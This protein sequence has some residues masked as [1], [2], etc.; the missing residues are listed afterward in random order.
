MKLLIWIYNDY[1]G[2]GSPGNWTF[3]RCSSPN[4]TKMIPSGSS[5]GTCRSHKPRV[6][7]GIGKRKSTL[8]LSQR[9]CMYACLHV[10]VCMYV[11]MELRLLGAAVH[12]WR[13]LLLLHWIEGSTHAEEDGDGGHGQDATDAAG[14]HG[15]I[16][17]HLGWISYGV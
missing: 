1:V 9:A 17:R 16:A 12:L 5:G 13:R 11:C 10:H 6:K 15:W 8:G 3:H 4:K 2:Y 7:S 14:K